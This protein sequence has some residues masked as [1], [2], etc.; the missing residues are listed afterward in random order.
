MLYEVI[1]PAALRTGHFRHMKI[2]DDKIWLQHPHEL[3]GFVAAMGR[4]DLD[5][6]TGEERFFHV[7]KECDV[8]NQKNFFSFV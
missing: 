3:Q 2:H 7:Q 8:V 1:T 4:R 6:F 5:A